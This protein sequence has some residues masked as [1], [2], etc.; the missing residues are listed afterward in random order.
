MNH[1]EIKNFLEL[2]THFKILDQKFEFHERKR[3][4]FA[5]FSLIF[6]NFWLFFVVK[7]QNIIKTATFNTL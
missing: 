5:I 4:F 1:V 7:M 2:L 3:D 6:T